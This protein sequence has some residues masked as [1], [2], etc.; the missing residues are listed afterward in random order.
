MNKTELTR[1]LAGILRDVNN[2]YINSLVNRETYHLIL[3]TMEKT[4]HDHGI[5]MSDVTDFRSLLEWPSY[6]DVY[7]LYFKE[8]VEVSKII[9]S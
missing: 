7:N 2:D 6:E 9:D 1:K 3:E 4:C 8:I 5:K